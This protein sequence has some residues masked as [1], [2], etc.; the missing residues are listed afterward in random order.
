M[1]TSEVAASPLG[2][3]EVHGAT[4]IPSRCLL[5][6]WSLDQRARLV[7]QFGVGIDEWRGKSEYVMQLGL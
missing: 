2:G 3:Q 5:Q 6:L 7:L 1:L 4:T